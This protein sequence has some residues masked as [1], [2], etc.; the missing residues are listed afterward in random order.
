MCVKVCR[1][2]TRL[3]NLHPSRIGKR[4]N[5]HQCLPTAFLE[6]GNLC[7]V[8]IL[9]RLHPLMDHYCFIVRDE[10]CP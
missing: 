5:I 1:Q 10:G 4:Q 7:G 2:G 6:T 9:T 8:T 3:T